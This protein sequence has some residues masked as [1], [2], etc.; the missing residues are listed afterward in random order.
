MNILVTGAAGF[1]GSHIAERLER[2]GYSVVPV[3][4]F[5]PNYDRAIKVANV[6][7]M[8]GTA[9][10]LAYVEET[11]LRERDAVTRL[12]REVS[13]GLVVHCAA[14]AG[15]R[16]SVE[17]PARYTEHNINGTVNL[18]EAMR[19][20]GCDKLVF[21]SSSSVYGA[22][23]TVPFTEEQAAVRPVSPYAAT[24][25]ACELLLHTYGGLYGL[26]YLS[27]RFFTIYGPRQRPDLAIHKFTSAVMRGQTIQMNG[28]GR[29]SRDYTHIGDIVGGVAAAVECLL[30]EDG[31]RETL[32]L[33]SSSPILLRDLIATIEEAC[34]REAVIERRA[35]QPGDVPRTFADVTKAHRLLGYEV[36]HDLR[37]GIH[38]FVG[39]WLQRFGD[40][41]GRR[42]LGHRAPEAG[43]HAREMRVGA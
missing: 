38:E 10:P 19:E 41:D 29:S 14:L 7:E 20:V 24:K 9:P 22:D 32:N 21:A 15:V 6:R 28:D 1:V 5:V 27:L 18:L 35:D 13:P 43:E 40:T 3:D 12:L 42:D 2:A 25:R 26:D 4:A 37:D 34:D 39:W 36:S 30:H 31:V 17:D 8:A 23:A 11:D 33:G 16:P